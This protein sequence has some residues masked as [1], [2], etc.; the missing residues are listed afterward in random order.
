[1]KRVFF[2]ILLVAFFGQGKL[3]AIGL[4]QY[5]DSL[6]AAQWPD[7]GFTAVWEPMKGSRP[8][9]LPKRAEIRLA[10][11]KPARWR[12]PLLLT[13]Q[14]DEPG[15]WRKTFS[16]RGTLRIFGPGLLPRER[17][18]QGEV[19]G[20]TKVQLAIV[21]YT[22]IAGTP[23]GC[24]SD[25]EGKVA[26]RTLV[27]SRPIVREHIRDKPIVVPGQEIYVE[28]VAGQVRAK[29]RARALEEGAQGEIIRASLSST[30][31]S[32]RVRLQ[33]AQTALLIQ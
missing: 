17:I 1:M 7:S 12:G 32:V 11:P 21:D 19:L 9:V 23:L 33:D 6:F 15:G 8:P 27:P 20:E 16:L 2:V 14:A 18:P 22:N 30:S 13:F 3:A 26:A 5:M 10:G 29:I 31:K 28:A 24:F 4:S 25:L